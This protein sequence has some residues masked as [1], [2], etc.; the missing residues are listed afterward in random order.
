MSSDR[1]RLVAEASKPDMDNDEI[2]VM[3]VT[4]S[5]VWWSEKR[6]AS[7]RYA[8]RACRG[9]EQGSDDR[10]AFIVAQYGLA[11]FIF[12]GADTRYATIDPEELTG[13]PPRVDA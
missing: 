3:I 6:Y 9:F 7:R 13:D 12:L 10:R 1:D 11:R 8:E 2:R 5:E 4:P